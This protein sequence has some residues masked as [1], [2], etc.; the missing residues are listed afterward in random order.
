MRVLPPPRT[1]GQVSMADYRAIRVV[2]DAVVGQ[3]KGR[4][5]PPE[6]SGNLE[7][8]VFG[9]RDFADRPITNG[10]SLFVYRLVTNGANRTPP[11]RVGPG[12]LRTKSR[13]PVEVHFLMTIWGG[14]A[15]LQLTLAGW[16]M[17]ALE[18]APLLTQPVLAGAGDALF[19][20]DELVELAAADLSNED[21]LRLW[22]TLGSG[23]VYQLSVPYVARVV[24]IDS[25]ETIPADSIRPVQQRLQDIGMNEHD[26]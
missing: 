18:D 20:P 12:G 8:R 2:A 9:S 21:L 11:G 17:R 23:V 22:D 13:L 10:I 3:L 24:Q 6:L 15:S 19:A 16:L 25:T 7:V 14:D 5:R 1:G 26:L 4:P